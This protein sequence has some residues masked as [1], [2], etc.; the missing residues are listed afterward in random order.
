MATTAQP[1]P[2]EPRTYIAPD[3]SGTATGT[4]GAD[5]IYA[6]GAG[7]T[8]IGNGGDDIFHIGTNTDA[9]IVENDA[10]ISTVDTWAGAYTLVDGVDNLTASGDSAHTLAG[11]ADANVITGAGG[12]DTILGGALDWLVGGGG[13]DTFIV[14]NGDAAD[15]IRDMQAGPGGDVVRLVGTGWTSFDEV[16][17]HMTDLPTQGDSDPSLPPGTLKH[18]SQLVLPSGERLNFTDVSMNDFTAANFAFDNSGVTPSPSPSPGPSPTPEPSSGLVVRVSGDYFD[19]PAQFTAVVGDKTYGPFTVTASHGAGEWQDILITP[20]VPAGSFGVNINFINDAW[21]GDPAHDRNMYV[22]YISVNGKL[23]QG[24]NA[25]A[26][27]ANG[28]S[29]SV[30]PNAGDMFTNGDL[31][32]YVFQGHAPPP[33]PSPSPGPSPTPSAEEPTPTPSEARGYVTPDRSGVAHGTAAAEDIF[34]SGDGQTL[35]GGGGD[36]IF[37]VGTYTGLTIDASGPGV[38]TV[39]TWGDFTLGDRVD[40]LTAEGAYGHT[41]TG[42]TLANVITGNTGNDTIYGGGGNDLLGGGGGD[43]VFRFTQFS[44]SHVADWS[45]GDMIDLRGLVSGDDQARFRVVDDGH[46]NAS[47]E[48]NTAAPSEAAHY[49]NIVTLDHVAASSINYH[50]TFILG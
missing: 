19:G 6:T 38:T 32:F 8:L 20:D 13:Q 29:N 7:Q 12:N 39:S 16:K 40:N 44:E 33:S 2:N 37:H 36:D 47:V 14:A 9:R 34:A 26:N 10:G 49:E 35:I 18:S 25:M 31:V 50:D 30:D 3:G 15:A 5:D 46:G 1:T 42:N 27:N 11:N 43:D 23:Y 28:G 45:Q 21:A 17:A 22:D 48:L 4:S 24:E 41:L